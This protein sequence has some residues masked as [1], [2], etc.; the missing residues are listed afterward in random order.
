[1]STIMGGALLTVAVAIATLTDLEPMR[2]V[3]I[4]AAIPIAAFTAATTMIG[5][6]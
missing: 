4:A 6:N 1:M 2:V 5:D 3:A